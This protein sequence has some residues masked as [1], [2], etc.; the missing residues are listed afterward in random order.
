MRNKAFQFVTDY[1]A[2]P[3]KD[4][5]LGCIHSGR[6]LHGSDRLVG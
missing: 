1:S 4:S 2:I 6:V 3:E 5:R